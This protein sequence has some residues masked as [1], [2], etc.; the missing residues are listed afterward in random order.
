MPPISGREAA[1]SSFNSR[2]EPDE[3]LPS[4]PD[5]LTNARH[6]GARYGSDPTMPETWMMFW[7]GSLSGIL[8][9]AAEPKSISFSIPVSL[10][11]QLS[12]FKSR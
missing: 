11:T 4:S 7:S 12:S 10:T 5:S 6:S 3:D 1:G 9:L 2:L 8:N